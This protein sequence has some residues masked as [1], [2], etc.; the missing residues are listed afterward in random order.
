M[1]SQIDSEVCAIEALSVVSQLSQYT[2][3]I[4]GCVKPTGFRATLKC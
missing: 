3:G 1:C 2:H 4:P